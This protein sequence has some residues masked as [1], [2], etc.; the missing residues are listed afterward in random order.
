MEG[1]AQIG[2]LSGVC[3]IGMQRFNGGERIADDFRGF[4]QKDV[5]QIFFFDGGIDD[6]IF[7]QGGNDRCWC[8]G[9]NG[10][11][12]RIRAL[13]FSS[14]NVGKR[15]TGLLCQRRLTSQLCLF[16]DTAELRSSRGGRQCA[17][18]LGADQI[19]QR[20]DMRLP[21]LCAGCGGAV[22]RLCR[23][24]RS[25]AAMCS[26]ITMCQLLCGFVEM[27][28]GFGQFRLI[29][30][31]VEHEGQGAQAVAQLQH[32]VL[33]LG[34]ID[35]ACLLRGI[36]QLLHLLRHDLNGSTGFFE[37][38]GEQNARDFVEL[39]RRFGCLG[40][41]LRMT[42]KVV[43]RLFDFTNGGTRFGN[44][45]SHAALIVEPRVQRFHPLGGRLHL[46]AA[47][48]GL[49]PLGQQGN[50]FVERVV[51]ARGFFQRSFQEQDGR[52]HFHGHFGMG[53]LFG[54]DNVLDDRLQ[55]AGEGR[56]SRP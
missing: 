56:G 6:A 27:E 13:F 38:E 45:L 24:S 46:F 4:F 1:P 12:Q 25:C 28:L 29:A 30:H 22:G 21:Q 11:C 18:C 52:R 54:L 32:D 36:D 42:E 17:C 34:H 41:F 44:N 50:A 53:G 14:L 3:H 51:I 2:Q 31:H 26:D 35:G 39:G 23:V 47:L 7:R 20:G 37:V 48:H 43:Q 55:S 15:L 9:G 49:E 8:Q 16:D 40:C 5:A 10:L 19:I 33:V